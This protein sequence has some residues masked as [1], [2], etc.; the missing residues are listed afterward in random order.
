MLTHVSVCIQPAS[1]HE[2][3]REAAVAFIPI[4]KDKLQFAERLV[5]TVVVM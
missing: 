3:Y 4:H 2:P 5:L 1:R